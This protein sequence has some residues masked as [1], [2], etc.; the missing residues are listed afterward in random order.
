MQIIQHFLNNSLRNF[1]Y[2]VYSDVTGEAVFFDPLDLEKTLPLAQEVGAVPKYLLT[3]H[4]HYDHIKDVD[5][6]LKLTDTE[7]LKLSDGEEFKLSETERIKCIDTPGHVKEHQCFLLIENDQTVGIICGDTIF[8]AGVGNCKNGGDPQV[9]ASTIEMLSQTLGDDVVIYPS[10]DYFASNLNFAK[11]VDPSNSLLE[12]YLKKYNQGYF[13]TTIG[14]EKK[15]NP[16][17]RAFS[18]NFAKNY[19]KTSRDLFI[20]IRSK[21]DK[22]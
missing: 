8:N 18:K 2:I 11:T 10:H 9:L 15:I 14:E 6:F 22:W 17:F 13:N 3:T 12:E 20:E 5:S 19:D 1:N 21:R 16:F 7:Y 4:N